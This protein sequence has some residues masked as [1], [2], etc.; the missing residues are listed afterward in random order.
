MISYWEKASFLNYDYVIVGGGIVGFSTALS[1]RDKHPKAS[2]LVLEAGFLPSGA[3]TKNAGFACVGSLSEIVDDLNHHSEEE[4][5]ELV[6]L[7]KDGLDLL[8]KRLGENRIRYEGTGSCELIFKHEVHLLDK[9]AKV[10][11][12]LSEVY[13][14]PIF[15]EHPK[16]ATAFGFSP[17][18][19]TM[20]YNRVEG[21]IH[22][23]EMM[24]T[25]IAKAQALGI[26]YKTGSRVIQLDEGSQGV[27]VHI[28]NEEAQIHAKQV[29][30]CTNAFTQTLLPNLDLKPGRGQVLITQPIPGLTLKGI[31][32]FDQGYYYFREID[33]RV[34]FGGGRNLDLEKETST[35][36]ELNQK[37]QQ[38]LEQKLR[39]LILPEYRVEIDQRWTG[40]MA[41]GSQKK[42]IVQA[43]SP[44]IFAGVRLGGMGVAIGS[45]L[46]EI[47]AN[48]SIR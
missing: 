35:A 24:K 33:G 38:D 16:G 7:R 48:L 9:I 40:I 46:G 30:V 12:L 13:H 6:K 21:A 3:S 2:I 39:F 22:T 31:F 8:K 4:V 42:P 5:C 27:V 11:K 34:L 26:E 20:I 18:V 10:N 19:Q 25:L 23:G 37:I 17:L 45:K 41:F 1:L 14:Y 36:D 29:F 47:L 28:Q 15:E 32:H 43:L 44:R